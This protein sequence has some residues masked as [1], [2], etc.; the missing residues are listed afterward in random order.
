MNLYEQLWADMWARLINPIAFGYF[1]ITHSAD[2]EGF[3]SYNGSE[4]D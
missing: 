2:L 3:C 1:E 4:I